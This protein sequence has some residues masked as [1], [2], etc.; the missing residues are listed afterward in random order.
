MAVDLF[1][2]SLVVMYGYS[3]AS[4]LS[5]VLILGYTLA[6]ITWTTYF[7]RADIPSRTPTLE[8][9]RRLQKALD[10]TANKAES[11]RETL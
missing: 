10:Y 8:Q 7:A 1:T 4:V 2:D 6:L 3:L 5:V 11:F 9:L